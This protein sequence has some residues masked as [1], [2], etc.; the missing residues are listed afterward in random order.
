MCH[1]K[2]PRQTKIETQGF[3]IVIKEGGEEY[4]LFPTLAEATEIAKIRAVKEPGAHFIVFSPT[5][6]YVWE[7]EK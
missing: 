4:E 1:L 5:R 3:A 2:I 6:G 7:G